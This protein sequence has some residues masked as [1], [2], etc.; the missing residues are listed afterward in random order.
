MRRKT[1]TLLIAAALAV[2]PAAAWSQAQKAPTF[3]VT[4]EV[5]ADQAGKCAAAAL[6]MQSVIKVMAKSAE[7]QE[8]LVATQAMVSGWQ[9]YISGRD[10]AFISAA[11]AAVKRDTE[12]YA[13]GLQGDDAQA[14]IQAGLAEHTRCL[15]WMTEG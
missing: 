15:G 9:V 3:K 12:A 4:G 10:P 13:A 8:L 5:A 14:T 6:L 7:D 11:Q 1:L 2:A